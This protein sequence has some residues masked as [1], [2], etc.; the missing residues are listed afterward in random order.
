VRGGGATLARFVYG[1]TESEALSLFDRAVRLT[2]GNVAVRYQVGLALAG[3]DLD[4]YHARIV[5]E[6]KAA[7]T[8]T[9]ETAYEKKIQGRAQELLGLMAQHEAFDALVR[10]YQGFP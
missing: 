1:A 7:I 5:T 9:A 8:D 3:F 4:K 2:P 6:L 10:K